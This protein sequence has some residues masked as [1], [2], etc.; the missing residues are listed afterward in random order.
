MKWSKT[1]GF[2]LFMM[3]AIPSWSATKFVNKSATGSNNGTSWASAWTDLSSI[4]WSGLAAGD[5]VCIAGGTYSGSITTGA[6]GTSGSPI[7]I[8]RATAADTT[9]GSV[10]AGWNSAFDGQVVMTGTIEIATSY[11]TI[12]GAVSNGIQV[13]MQN[14]SG[15]AY[16]G[17]GGTSASTHNVTLRYIEVAGPCGSTPCHNLG[18][19][20]S[21]VIEHWNGSDYDTQDSWLLQYMNF[22]GA[23]NNM[24]LY[25]ETNLVIEHSRLADSLDSVGDI[26]HPNVGNIG[27]GTATFRYNEVVNWDTEGLMF[28][29]TG[30][31]YIY[32]NIWHDP[33][34][35]SYPRY[36]ESQTNNM[37][38]YSY[39]NTL[40]NIPYG[41][42]LTSNGGT[43]SSSSQG[44]NNI[45]WNTN[46]TGGFSSD[47]YDFSNV[48][49]SETHGQ[50]KASNPFVSLTGENYHLTAHTNA[51][52]SLGSPYNVDYDGNTR[53][54]W[55]RGAYEFATGIS[56]NPPTNLTGTAH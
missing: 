35:S 49:L 56:P 39:N 19:H 13:I 38:V 50:G 44:R 40:A 24:V 4:G 29:G 16:V 11:V 52:L 33:S 47:D 41:T 12:D 3:A 51:G 2:I 23:C 5:V 27:G 32:G 20:R 14:P 36:L 25:G 1:V 18:D 53:T 17:V 30:T 54:T 45:Y 10:T 42:V 37:L 28:L 22:H 48:S 46:G 43:W 6:S 15:S 9:C 55:D 7:T 31:W 26:C 21:F 34:T 8:R